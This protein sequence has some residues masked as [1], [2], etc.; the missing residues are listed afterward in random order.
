MLDALIT[1]LALV[2]V[3]V[4]LCWHHAPPDA[5]GD[6]ATRP[7]HPAMLRP[8][9]HQKMLR[10]F[11]FIISA[12]AGFLVVTYGGLPQQSWAPDFLAA[13]AAWVATE[14]LLR[15]FTKI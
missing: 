10:F 6:W 9:K 14:V 11:Q 3:G 13:A 8:T 5:N 4:I 15:S 7:I 1:L 12:A 2:V